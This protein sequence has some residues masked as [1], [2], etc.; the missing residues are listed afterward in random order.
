MP[1]MDAQNTPPAPQQP[2]QPAATPLSTPAPVEKKHEVVPVHKPPQPKSN[3]PKG[4]AFAIFFAVVF[5]SCL[6]AVAYLA[7][8]KSK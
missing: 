3:K 6:A 2:E 5:V 1:T 8:S 4:P 7:Y